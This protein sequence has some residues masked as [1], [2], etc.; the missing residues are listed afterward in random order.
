MS[1]RTVL[2]HIHIS[3]PY[4]T[5][6]W[7]SWQI[8]K[9]FRHVPSKTLIFH[10]LVH[11]DVID[12][13]QIQNQ[14]SRGVC[15]KSYTENMQQI[16]KRTLMLK[17]DVNKVA[18]QFYW[19]HTSAWVLF[20]KYVTYFQNTFSHEHHWMAASAGSYDSVSVSYTL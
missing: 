15:K 17:C 5:A 4:W 6:I 13:R 1:N 9:G 2:W 8:S 12:F 20:F 7:F 14:P 3:R 10:V 16:Y 19:N 18:L 11:H